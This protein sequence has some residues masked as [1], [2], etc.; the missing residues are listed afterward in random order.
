MVPTGARWICGR[1]CHRARQRVLRRGTK[2]GRC[3]LRHSRPNCDGAF[4]QG[5]RLRS[6]DW[7]RRG[8]HGDLGKVTLRHVGWCRRAKWSRRREPAV[9]AG[10]ARWLG[11]LAAEVC[12]FVACVERPHPFVHGFGPAP[13]A[14]TAGACITPGDQA[15]PENGDS[16]KQYEWMKAIHQRVSFLRGR[17]RSENRWDGLQG[18][19]FTS[20]S[21]G[22]DQML[23]R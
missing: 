23:R 12:V 14:V 17:N 10:P 8:R 5:T 20:P 7:R 13:A 2:T 15:G 16:D 21:G 11:T 18:W 3:G 4:L 19:Q 1:G 6:D 9:V 22:G